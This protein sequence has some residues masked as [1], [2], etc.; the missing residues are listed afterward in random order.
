MESENKTG[1]KLTSMGSLEDKLAFLQQVG[2]KVMCYSELKE[3]LVLIRM[4]L[5]CRSAMLSWRK[6]EG[7]WSR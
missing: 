3:T 1:S 5:A 6:G 7:L 4:L 2:L